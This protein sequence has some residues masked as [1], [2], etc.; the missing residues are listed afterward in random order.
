MEKEKESNR[1]ITRT[2]WYQTIIKQ[3]KCT[4]QHTSK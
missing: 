3:N 2:V 1:I 4:A